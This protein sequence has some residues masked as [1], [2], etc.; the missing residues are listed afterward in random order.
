[1]VYRILADG[2]M[3]VHFAFILFI[4]V[5]AVLAW[6]WPGVLWA[7]VPALAWGVGT[8]AIG[9]PCPLTA[10]EKGLRRLAGGAGYHGGFVDRYIENVIYPGDYTVLLR[11]LAALAIAASYVAVLRRTRAASTATAP[12]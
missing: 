12:Q 8:V 2:V 10:L 6:R 3:V 11:G 5:G 9:F 7:H 4:V 1:M